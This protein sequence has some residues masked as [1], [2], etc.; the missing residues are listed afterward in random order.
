MKKLLFTGLLLV[1]FAACQNE[2]RYSQTSPEVEMAKS[3]IKD[4]DAKN[5]ESLVSHY[6]DTAN[7]FLNSITSFKASQLPDFH[8]KDDDCLSI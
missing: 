7:V 4:Y 2:Q 6:A 5:Y 1:L 3:I 8:H